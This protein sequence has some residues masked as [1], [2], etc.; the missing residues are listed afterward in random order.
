M[1]WLTWVG[2]LSQRQLLS[3]G[4]AGLLALHRC[5]FFLQICLHVEANLSLGRVSIALMTIKQT[6]ITTNPQS[7]IITG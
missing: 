7:F 6:N 2:F 1:A 3:G 4:R 5:L